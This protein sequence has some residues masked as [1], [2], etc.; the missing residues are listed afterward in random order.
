MEGKVI[1]SYVLV[2]NKSMKILLWQERRR[3]D[4]TLIM[5]SQMSGVSKT[6]LNDI[7][8]EKHSPTLDQLE[9]IAKGMNCR[10]SDLYDSE[11]K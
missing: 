1:K 2:Y 8:N 4:L 9:K 5:L 10:M 3:R 7:E 6:T 11:Y